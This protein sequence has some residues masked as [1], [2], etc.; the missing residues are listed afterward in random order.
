MDLDLLWVPLGVLVVGLIV[1]ALL[2]G[3]LVWAWI[4]LTYFGFHIKRYMYR[5][6]HWE[7]SKE[8]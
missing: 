5:L 1:G 6:S 8:D 4:F 3:L 2:I 7:K